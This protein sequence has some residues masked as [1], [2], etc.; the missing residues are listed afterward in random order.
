MGN[1]DHS[2]DDGCN[3]SE[4]AGIDYGCMY[5]YGFSPDRALI[6]MSD[7]DGLLE[8]P[9][10]SM[11]GKYYTERTGILAK[12]P[13][14]NRSS[15]LW[16]PYSFSDL[17]ERRF[18]VPGA[19]AHPLCCSKQ[20]YPIESSYGCLHT[21][22]DCR[23]L[24]DRVRKGTVETVK[25]RLSQREKTQI[26]PGSIFVYTEQESGIRRWTDKKEWSPS[27]VQGCFLVYRELQG[28]LLKK[29]YASMQVEGAYHIVV[30][31]LMSWD[32]QGLCCE[33]FKGRRRSRYGRGPEYVGG[34]EIVEDKSEIVRGYSDGI[35]DAISFNDQKETQ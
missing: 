25:K 3:P 31:S 5:Y 10:E 29:T 32:V 20:T 19:D 15:L 27:R 2:P 13:Q 22:A 6:P 7:T 14:G 18:D 9:V 33:Y 4:D 30:Y 1:G 21:E 23:R 8:R 26:R 17:R 16:P 28:Q 24:I 34:A 35:V 11:A 12:V